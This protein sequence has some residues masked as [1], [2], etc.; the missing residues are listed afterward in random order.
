MGSRD[1]IIRHVDGNNS[2]ATMKRKTILLAALAGAVLTSGVW[3]LLP[4]P[5]PKWTATEIETLRSLSLDAM[6]ALPPAV[7]APGTVRI[8]TDTALPHLGGGTATP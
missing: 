5:V 2:A 7:L 3:Q 4:K 8:R 1:V 6:L